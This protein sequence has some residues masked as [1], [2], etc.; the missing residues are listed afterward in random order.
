MSPSKYPAA[1]KVAAFVPPFHDV[2][3]ADGMLVHAHT[4][5]QTISHHISFP[6]VYI[7]HI[8]H[9][10]YKIVDP[11][12]TFAGPR[13]PIGDFGYI[14]N[15]GVEEMGDENM[16]EGLGRL[17]RY[18]PS[19][20]SLLLFNTSENP[21]KK[22]V[23]LDNLAGTDREIVTEEKKVRYDVAIQWLSCF[24]RVYSFTHIH[25]HT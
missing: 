24:H 15:R 17:P 7:P 23:S 2:K 5:T 14:T 20:S 1:E 18:L 4:H 9:K 6:L 10:P 12:T 3:T 16:Q 13:D 21:Y 8:A 11:Y 22:Y 25:T 19:V